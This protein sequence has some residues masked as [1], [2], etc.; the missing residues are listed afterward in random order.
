[1]IIVDTGILVAV[2]NRADRWH[3][4]ATELLVARRHEM[5]VPAPVVRDS[6]TARRIVP[7]PTRLNGRDSGSPPHGS[8]PDHV[9]SS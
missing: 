4:Q 2:A 7:R 3:D 5:L 6:G 8:A 9:G 1:M